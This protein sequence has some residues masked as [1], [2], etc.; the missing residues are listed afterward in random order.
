MNNELKPQSKSLFPVEFKLDNLEFKESALATDE[1]EM[2]PVPTIQA[3]IEVGIEV[4]QSIEEIPQKM[5]F[6]IGEVAEMVGVKQYVLRYW[7]GEFEALRPR[8]SKNNQRVYTRRDVE[9]AL[10]IKKLLYKD[11]FS[12]EG[13]RVALKQLRTQVKE[14]RTQKQVHEPVLRTLRELLE[15][16]QALKQRLALQ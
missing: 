15:D 8:K 12:I 2:L 6:K 5:A 14:E 7:E 9:T 11:R 10:L 3:K 16:I 4:L 13:A 1:I